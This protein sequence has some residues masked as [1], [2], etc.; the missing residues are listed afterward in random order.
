MQSKSL[1]SKLLT[2]DVAIS[3]AKDYPEIKAAVAEYNYDDARLDEGLALQ[4][5]ADTL[6]KKQIKEYGDQF[7][8]T[9]DLD[10]I[11]GKANKMYMKHLKVARI[12]MEDNLALIVF[13]A[14]RP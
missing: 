12:T 10:S 7:Q 9:N 2:T 1:E 5:E 14:G 13:D 4:K 6:H 8:A 3:A 11:K